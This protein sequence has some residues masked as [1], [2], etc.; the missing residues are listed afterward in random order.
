MRYS[1]EC[2]QYEPDAGLSGIPLIGAEFF[3][4]ARGV[5]AYELHDS[6][7]LPSHLKHCRRLDNRA[8]VQNN[9]LPMA[10]ITVA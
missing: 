1:M 10:G 8:Q 3:S 4:P 2:T 7:A 9:P 6:P 5:R